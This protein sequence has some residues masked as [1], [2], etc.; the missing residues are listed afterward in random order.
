[1]HSAGVSDTNSSL[2]SLDRLTYLLSGDLQSDDLPLWEIVWTLNTL[3][4]GAPLDEK[5]RLAR[6]AVSVLVGQHDLWRGEWPTGPVAPLTEHERQALADDDAAWHD[7]EHA[8]LL[9]WLR[10]EGSSAGPEQS[11]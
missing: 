6:R 8:T 11:G 5:I 2:P 4:P 10:E 1:V 7:P 9:V 3:A